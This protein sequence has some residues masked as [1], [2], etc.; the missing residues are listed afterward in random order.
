MALL[1]AL[2]IMTAGCKQRQSPVTL[3]KSEQVREDSTLMLPDFKM[4]LIGGSEMSARAE[5]AQ[6]QLTILDFW[7]SWCGP[8]RAEMPLMVELYK[9]YHAK[10]LGIIGISLDEDEQA[11]KSAVNSMHMNW[12][13]V[14][15]LNGWDNR[16]AQL[17]GIESIPYTIVVNRQGEILETG[18]RGE[19]LRDYVKRY[20]ND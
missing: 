16:A 7:A 14:S 13:Q 6:H 20:I 10:G 12:T 11:W 1:V 3:Q 9:D 4:T 19:A 2:G 18:L 5:V 8:C 17:F 15:D